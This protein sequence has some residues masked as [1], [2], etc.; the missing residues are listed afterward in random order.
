MF[1]CPL[2]VQPGSM[3]ATASPH[4]FLGVDIG[5]VVQQQRHDGEV[6]VF[7]CEVKGGFVILHAPMA[8]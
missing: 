2:S 1:I 3:F 6:A 7:S 8:T 4:L 5:G